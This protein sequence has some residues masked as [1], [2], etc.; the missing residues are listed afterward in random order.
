MD[1]Q[2]LERDLLSERLSSI[3]LHKDN[4]GK[5]GNLVSYINGVVNHDVTVLRD[6]HVVLSKETYKL[7]LLLEDSY[8]HLGNHLGVVNLTELM[9]Y[10]FSDPVYSSILSGSDHKLLLE[11]INE[12]YED[13]VVERIKDKAF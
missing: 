8:E 11:T 5:V 6:T 4:F 12:A 13:F 1:Y 2:R 7:E 9:Y 3:L 10:I